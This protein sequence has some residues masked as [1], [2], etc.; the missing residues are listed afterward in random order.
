VGVRGTK[1]RLG[2]R[3]EKIEIQATERINVVVV[4]KRGRTHLAH[5]ARSGIGAGDNVITLPVPSAVAGGGAVLSITVTDAA[6][7]HHTW[8]RAVILP[9]G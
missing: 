6:E 3:V 4:L 2:F 9:H 8:T 5:E 7:R 1:S